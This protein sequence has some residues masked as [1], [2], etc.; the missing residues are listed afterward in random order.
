VSTPFFLSLLC[1][2][3]YPPSVC[4]PLSPWSAGIAETFT[5]R[6]HSPIPG[7]HA[8]ADSK[9]LAPVT[10]G[11]YGVTYQIL[12]QTL[13]LLSLGKLTRT[14]R[15]AQMVE[16]LP[17]KNETMSSNPTQS[18]APALFTPEIYEGTRLKGPALVTSLISKEGTP[19]RCR[20]L[21]LFLKG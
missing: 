12:K 6:S 14:G 15:V 10:N 18:G 7:T 13:S 16:C 11:A 19:H 3:V 9:L 4:L 1:P 17:N 2:A 5:S 21:W 20:K 8:P